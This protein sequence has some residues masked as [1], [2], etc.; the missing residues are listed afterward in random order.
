[1]ARMMHDEKCQVARCLISSC[2][3]CNFVPCSRGQSIWFLSKKNMPKCYMYLRISARRTR[4]FEPRRMASSMTRSDQL[5]QFLSVHPRKPGYNPILERK[6][7]STQKPESEPRS[8]DRRQTTH[9]VIPL[10]NLGSTAISTPFLSKG[11]KTLNTA[12]TLAIATHTVVSAKCL[13]AH[14]RRPNPN[15]MCAVS[16]GLSEPS[17][18]KNRSGMNACGSGYLASSCAIDLTS[19]SSRAVSEECRAH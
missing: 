10:E 8:F 11:L 2:A 5:L 9:T 13:P 6:R 14:M 4:R 17:S 16:L 1:M 7:L 18:F 12:N 3:L 15:V 19:G